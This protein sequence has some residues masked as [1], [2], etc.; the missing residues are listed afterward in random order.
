MNSVKCFRRHILFL[1]SLLM[2]FL[3]VRGQELLTLSDAIALGI[4]HNFDVRIERIDAEISANNVSPA[5]AGLRP[6]ISL[7]G[8]AQFGYSGTSTETIPLGPPSESNSDVIKLDGFNTL[9]SI[10]PELSFVLFDGYQGKYR[11]QQFETING[12]SQLRLENEVERVVM[13]IILA[14]IEV[15]RQQ[16]QL[17]ID[18][19][20]IELSSQRLQRISNAGEY[21]MANS[22]QRL[23]AETNLKT[24][25]VA[26]RNTTLSLEN[27]KR[28]LSYLINRLEE[29]PLEVQPQIEFAEKKMIYEDLRRDLTGKNT[30]LLLSQKNVDLAQQGFDIAKSKFFPVISGFANLNYSYLADDANFLQR[31]RV[32]GTAVGIRVNVP[33]YDGGIR[34]IEEENALLTFDQNRMKKEQMGV[35]LQK[36][37]RN[38]YEQYANSR[39]QLRIET[40]NLQLFLTTYEK[41]SEDFRLGLATATEIREAQLSL[42]AAKNRINNLEYTVKQAE[43]LLLQLSGNLL[44]GR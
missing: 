6:Q 19:E 1:F 44:S 3:T 4:E 33:I 36:E 16:R 9:L 26:Y 17:V 31:N 24:D 13:Q 30:L 34:K 35:L 12:L 25:S 11:L 5:L 21:G 23:Q 38:A 8:T 15:A 41:V 37:L 43:V 10:G 22:I 20:N 7:N 39:E 27:A 32:A 14:Y 40:S 18:A 28:N 29:T 2:P 42:N